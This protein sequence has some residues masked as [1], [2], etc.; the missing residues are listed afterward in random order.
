M[1]GHQTFNEICSLGAACRLKVLQGEQ[2]KVCKPIVILDSFETVFVFLSD[3]Y[4]Y[5]L[6]I[7]LQS[8]G[9]SI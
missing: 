4:N 1:K 6:E 2:V 7:I 9:A 5:T 8:L 3:I